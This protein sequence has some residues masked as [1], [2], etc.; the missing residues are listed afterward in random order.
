[1]TGDTVLQYST[2]GA[3]PRFSRLAKFAF[4]WS[5]FV[6]AAV[7]LALSILA[8]RLDDIFD[9]PILVWIF[10]ACSTAAP[11]AAV[12]LGGL[13]LGTIRE[14]RGRL[15]GSSFAIVAVVLGW[16]QVVGFTVLL[17]VAWR[18]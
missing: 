10:G 1:M 18:M 17:A 13:A 8:D 12:F 9:R 16:A 2:P 14:S 15:N 6:P 5:A 4:V 7:M 11:L 3:G